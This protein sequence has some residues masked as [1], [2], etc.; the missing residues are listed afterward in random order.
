MSFLKFFGV[1]WSSLEFLG[2]LWTSYLRFPV[3]CLLHL[4]NRVFQVFFSFF[5]Y[6]LFVT[7]CNEKVNFR[8]KVFKSFFFDLNGVI[9]SFFYWCK[10]CLF[11]PNFERFR[12]RQYFIVQLLFYLKLQIWFLFLHMFCMYQKEQQAIKTRTNLQLKKTHTS[13]FA[14]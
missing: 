13:F 3:E 10:K 1:P 9:V 8:S 11:L 2:V 6:D 5:T 12:K 7:A 14:R 4:W